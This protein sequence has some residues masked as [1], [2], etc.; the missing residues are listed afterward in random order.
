MA[1]VLGRAEE[2]I[3]SEMRTRDEFRRPET[4][5]YEAASDGTETAAHNEG[6]DAGHDSPS[7]G[8]KSRRRQA[9]NN[10]T[11]TH[12]TTQLLFDLAR[13]M[14]PISMAQRDGSD[15]PWLLGGCLP[16]VVRLPKAALHACQRI[17]RCQ[18]P[19][20]RPH[21][22][23]HRQPRQQQLPATCGIYSDQWRKPARRRP[24]MTVQRYQS[25]IPT[26]R[27]KHKQLLALPQT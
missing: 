21:L 8:V 11:H 2:D 5:G 9:D 25:A 23:D 24:T 7:C 6:C 16:D 18:P 17:F 3:V 19:G 22:Y 20:K 14:I 10:H 4:G 26:Q 13:R 1:G 15:W 27:R 12:I